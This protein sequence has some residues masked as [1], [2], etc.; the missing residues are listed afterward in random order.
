MYTLS[1]L[2]VK[3]MNL[4]IGQIYFCEKVEK[5]NN[6]HFLSNYKDFFSV[7]LQ[8]LCECISPSP[9][10]INFNPICRSFSEKWL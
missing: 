8:V 3:L 6:F 9:S 10:A 4:K 2:L 1:G 7:F 5:Y